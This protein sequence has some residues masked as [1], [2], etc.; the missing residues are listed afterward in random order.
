MLP[1]REALGVLST[2]DTSYA[3]AYAA[4]SGWD[5]ATGIGSV[6]AFN[7]LNAFVD[8]T[9]PSSAPAAP[10][11]ISPAN[12]AT[13]VL[14]EATLAWNVSAGAT[15]YDVYFGTAT[16]PPLVT[17]TANLNYAPGALSAGTTYYWAVGA[18]NNLGANVS[19][20]W[21]FTTSCV[22]ALN[23]SGAAAPP[24]GGAG[25]I[26]V[27]ATAGCGWTAVSNVSWIAITSG[28]SGN[29]NGTVGYTVTADSAPRNARAPSLL[30]ARPSR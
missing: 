7:L 17:N 24:A 1:G 28:A 4:A 18:R 22:S 10:L 14:P 9:V 13:G 25:T 30:R 15:S 11:P 26:P 27:I 6:N 5:F 12:G 2:S 29:G 19:A 23:P 20:P 21:S 3:P 16:P 8:S